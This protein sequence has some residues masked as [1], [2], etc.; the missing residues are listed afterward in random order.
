MSAKRRPKFGSANQVN[1]VDWFDSKTMW[2]LS[3]SQSRTGRHVERRNRFRPQCE[4]MDSRVL[5]SGLTPPAFT[6]TGVSTTQVGLSWTSVPG[7]TGYYVIEAV[8][9]KWDFIGNL[10]SNST[11]CTVNNL[12]PG[13]TYVF[14]VGA[15]NAAG[16]AWGSPQYASTQLAAPAAPS[17]TAS[18]ISTTQISLAWTSV[19]GATG[20]YV[21][22]AVNGKWDFIGNMGSGSTGCTVN[23]LSPGATYVFD[24]GATTQPESL[25]GVLNPRPHP[26][27]PSR[28]TTRR[29]RWTTAP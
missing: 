28:W 24:V 26:Q 13:T 20:Y 14:D 3:S 1:V 27:V 12:S 18:G 21:I 9:N 17:F 4:S 23:N 22:E 16:V 7:A 11:G 2:R 6:A 19:P 5:L 10:N 25:G 29:R 15:Y 8:N